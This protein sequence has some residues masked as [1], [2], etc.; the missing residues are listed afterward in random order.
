MIGFP[1]GK[2]AF[3]MFDESDLRSLHWG[4]LDVLENAGI[5]V[6]S[7]ECLGLL[8]DAGCAVDQKTSIAKIPGN[9]VEEAIRKAKKN[10]TLCART[11]KYD[12]VLDGRRTYCTTDGNG[13]SVM[14]FKTGKRRMSTSED[15]AMVGKVAN[16]LDSAHIFWP[17]V[18]CQDVP[19]YLRH[20]V[21]LK[22]ALS[23]IE[24]HVQVET[25][26]HRREAKWLVEIGASLAGDKK[27][28]R[29]KPIFS[30]MH[31]PFSPLQL[32][33]GSTEGALEL[34]RAGVPISFYG[35]PQ[36]GITGPVTLAGSII[37]NNAEVLGGL[38]MAQLA[39]PGSPFMYGT[40][41]AA[42]DMRTMTWAGGGP[43]RALISAGAGE[44]AHYYGFSILCGGIVTSAKLP[45][46]QACYEK[47]SSGMPQ[48]YA[49]CDMVAGLGLLDDVTM[50]SYEQMVID[51]E[52][53]RIMARLA[54][55]VTIDDDHLAV[56]IIKKVGPGGSFL[57][58]RHTM[59]WLHKEHFITDITDRRT[60]E[61][62]EADGKKSVVERA[63]DKAARIMKEHVVQSV[64]TDVAKDF[65]RIVKDADKDI[66]TRGLD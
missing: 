42:F 33:G 4:T 27:A 7:K 16:A 30:S 56:D 54:Q 31:C 10:L 12:V 29:R 8:E 59:Q 58:E 40:G 20:V 34:A 57:A 23:S 24:K 2:V 46:P 14:D 65:E 48:F 51:D 5:K 45:G 53:A 22:V 55:G 19:D 35:M 52:M 60:G 32:D 15:L 11:P 9:L 37:V 1:K 13:T 43:E 44:L 39:A 49:G 6:I 47:M 63:R 36:A 17:C 3:H 18:S 50:L 38:T 28:L 21:D 62:W 26:S 41:G 64:P 66:K 25:T 61:A